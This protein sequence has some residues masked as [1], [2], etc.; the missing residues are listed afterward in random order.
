MIVNSMKAAIF[1]KKVTRVINA[2]LQHYDSLANGEHNKLNPKGPKRFPGFG[3]GY[4]NRKK[5]KSEKKEP[6]E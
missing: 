1:E 5:D 6:T 4:Y 2:G 3:K